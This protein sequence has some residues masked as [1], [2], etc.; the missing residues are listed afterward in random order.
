MAKKGRGKKAGK[1]VFRLAPLVPLAPGR[2]MHGVAILKVRLL[3]SPYQGEDRG[4]RVTAA[5]RNMAG[6]KP[7]TAIPAPSYIPPYL[8]A[9]WGEYET[10]QA[11]IAKLPG[12]QKRLRV[13]GWNSYETGIDYG[14]EGGAEEQELDDV[15]EQ[16]AER[17]KRVD[18]VIL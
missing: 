14:K 8:L 9:V 18:E 11:A 7:F 3:K 13:C 16:Y 4:Y 15:R 10:Y 6:V 12:I 2:A 5:V 1:A 17:V